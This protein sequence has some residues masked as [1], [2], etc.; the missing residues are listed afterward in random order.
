MLRTLK[1]MP[2]ERNFDFIQEN[3]TAQSHVGFTHSTIKKLLYFLLSS[4]TR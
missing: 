2:R 4:D 1:V 3:S